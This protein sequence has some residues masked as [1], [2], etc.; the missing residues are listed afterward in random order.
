VVSPKTGR[1]TPATFTSPYLLWQG[2]FSSGVGAALEILPDGTVN[3][4][5]GTTLL[6]PH[7]TSSPSTVLKLT[8]SQV[9]DLFTLLNTIDFAKL[10]H[11]GSGKD[12]QNQFHLEN[13]PTAATVDLAYKNAGELK[14][15]LDAV[16]L[17]L[18]QNIMPTQILLPNGYC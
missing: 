15:E 2:A 10:P 17:W 7:K 5:A 18:Q 3:L 6:Q 4:W 11:T 16:Y 14:P 8:P 1:C 9:Q 13:W 12:C